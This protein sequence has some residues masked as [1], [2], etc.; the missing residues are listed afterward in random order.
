[1]DA[2]LIAEKVELWHVSAVSCA[3]ACSNNERIYGSCLAYF[4]GYY[5]TPDAAPVRVE[6]CFI[7]ESL[8]Q[9]LIPPGSTVTNTQ[10]ID[11]L[12]RSVVNPYD[13]RLQAIAKKDFFDSPALTATPTPSV[14]G[15]NREAGAYDERGIIE[16]TWKS[17]EIVHPWLM[18][19]ETDRVRVTNR[20][21]DGV[22]TKYST[23]K[24][25]VQ[26]RLQWRVALSEDDLRNLERVINADESLV[27]IYFNPVSKPT[28]FI[29]GYVDQ[30]MK[31]GGPMAL[32]SNVSEQVSIDV[33]LQQPGESLFD[34]I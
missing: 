25:S 15:G 28:T 4:T 24:T 19:I 21:R 12:F 31:H 1:V 33:D 27:R 10:S 7:R 3:Y 17:F 23:G 29:T 9:N 18:P 2:Y 14:F 34:W 32:L 20:R 8:A 26:L 11:P 22:K 5:L 6:Y 13:L 30:S 16:T